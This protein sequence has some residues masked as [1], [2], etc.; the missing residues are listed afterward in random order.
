MPDQIQT[1]KL[2]PSV[3]SGR[4]AAEQQVCVLLVGEQ[5][6]VAGE[7][8]DCLAGESNLEFHYCVE[9]AAAIQL[10]GHLHPTV[11]LHDL[12][13]PDAQVFF[14]IDQLRA[15]TIT[16][17]IP[18]IILSPTENPA[19]RSRVFALGANDFLVKLPDKT[20]LVAADLGHGEVAGVGGGPDR[21][22]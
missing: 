4:P 17:D 7:I 9:P 2:H 11:I 22:H 18:V 13:H 16:K 20:E 10:A 14:A 1:A 5:A 3:E 6:A 12:V 21:S 15:H 8:R 19:V